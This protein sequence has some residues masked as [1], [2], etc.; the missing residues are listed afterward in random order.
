MFHLMVFCFAIVLLHG[1]N[2]HVF[3]KQD[4]QPLKHF[5]RQDFNITDECVD[6]KLAESSSECVSNIAPNGIPDDFDIICSS[7]CGQI[8]LN[9]L[10]DCGVS[11]AE[12]RLFADFCGT[13]SDGDVCYSVLDDFLT[14]ME[15]ADNVNCSS[16]EI[17]SNS[18]HSALTQLVTQIGCCFDVLLDFIGVADRNFVNLIKERFEICD[19]DLPG[20]CNNS[21]VSGSKAFFQVSSVAI[22]ALVL[23]TM[24]G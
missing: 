17:C 19:I 5:K 10:G 3:S 12:M 16:N 20:E 6:T 9:L 4:V 24:L 1:V 22:C 11:D 14:S 8:V 18:C 13:N 7:D 21:P 15:N 23:I 2:S